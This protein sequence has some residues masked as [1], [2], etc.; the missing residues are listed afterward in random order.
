MGEPTN[1]KAKFFNRN[2]LKWIAIGSLLGS[3]AGLFGTLSGE[4]LNT[5]FW[6]DNPLQELVL[7]LGLSISSLILVVVIWPHLKKIPDRNISF[8]AF[9]ML[10]LGVF[11][12]N[13]P[14]HQLQMK[15]Q[16][17]E[18]AVLSIPVASQAIQK[19]GSEHGIDQEVLDDIKREVFLEVIKSTGD[20]MVDRVVQD[21][22]D[23]ALLK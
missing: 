10:G 2:S 17:L 1:V 4:R 19:I 16:N 5:K 12:L 11:A 6:F 3:F 22:V 7:S 20:L 13:A 18:G 14:F 8:C 23:E 21:R 15:F 9:F